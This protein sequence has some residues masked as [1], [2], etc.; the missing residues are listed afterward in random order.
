MKYK[1]KT[2]LFAALAILGASFYW[3]A[4]RVVAQEDD[5]RF[6]RPAERN[7]LDDQEPSVSSTTQ[8]GPPIAQRT[9]TGLLQPSS[10]PRPPAAMPNVFQPSESRRGS[11]ASAPVP[12]ASSSVF[13]GAYVPKG[14]T[15]VEYAQH[16]PSQGKQQATVQQVS[17]QEPILITELPPILPSGRA[18]RALPPIVQ[19]NN[20]T[21]QIVQP[22]KQSKLPPVVHPVHAANE[23]NLPPVVPPNAGLNRLLSRIQTTDKNL[24]NDKNDSLATADGSSLNETS[25]VTQA[26]FGATPLVVQDAPPIVGSVVEDS[27]TGSLP[28]LDGSLVPIDPTVNVPS[29]GGF[30]PPP[31]TP[32]SVTAIPQPGFEQAL[33]V[34]QPATTHETYFEPV[35]QQAPVFG[36]CSTCGSGGGGCGCSGGHGSGVSACTSC[37]DGGCFD[38]A[39]VESIFNS[40]G[41]NAY[42]RR[43]VIAEALY[44]DRTEGQINNSNFGS[45]NNFDAGGGARIT[46]GQR[47]DSTRGREFQY[48]GIA[49]AEQTLQI[50]QPAGLANSQFV[51]LGGLAGGSLGAF[52]NATE[53]SQ[54]AETYF[55]SLEFNR[56][57]WGWDVIKS[58]VGLRYIYVDDEYTLFSQSLGL[59]GGSLTPAESGFFQLA[60]TNHLIGPH[61]GGE[62]YYDIGYRWSLSGV[63]RLGAYLNI[64]TFDTQLVNN[65]TEFINA[66]DTNSTISFTYEIGLNAKFRLTR[67][68]QFRVGYNILFFDNLA[69]ASDNLLNEPALG[70]GIPVSPTLGSSTS[71]EESVLFHGLSIG[72]EIYR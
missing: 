67:Q 55:H 34:Q 66:E 22:I 7:R 13:N 12:F 18:E 68:A 41:A 8:A 48:S 28:S 58:Y 30:P 24:T 43:Y 62:L 33:P 4:S 53:Q 32:N 37:G 40:S 17:H 1:L 71:D 63:S 65:G 38:P 59:A 29:E 2:R 39:Q 72:F 5:F 35:A 19:S 61:L 50:F 6:I 47:T 15:G 54:S 20:S 26:S 64:N 10:T 11:A 45:L 70:G 56:V 52:F 23:S 14:N 27:I 3:P 69:T 21:P 36:G 16:L 9:S 49:P 57:K 44:F 42:A 51:P 60:A 25:S 31:A 46:V